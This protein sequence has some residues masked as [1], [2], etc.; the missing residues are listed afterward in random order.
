MDE[1]DTLRTEV[2]HLRRLLDGAFEAVSRAVEGTHDLNL[3][4]LHDWLDG[5]DIPAEAMLCEPED[6]DP[7]IPC[8]RQ[9]PAAEIDLLV[10]TEDREAVVARYSQGQWDY[11][12]G[13]VR[14]V[15]DWMPLP[16]PPQP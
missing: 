2:A 12:D 6:G 4:R 16:P 11:G 13:P 5:E 14:G 10:W 3:T 9:M 15:T 1:L 7:W 8:T